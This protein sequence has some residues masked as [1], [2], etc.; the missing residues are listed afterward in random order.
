MK[1]SKQELHLLIDLAK[2]ETIP[3]TTMIDSNGKAY[4]HAF[5]S[6]YLVTKNK[7]LN[8]RTNNPLVLH[9]VITQDFG[10]KDISFTDIKNFIN[11]IK[12]RLNIDKYF[13]N[14]EK[15]HGLSEDQLNLVTEQ[16]ISKAQ[17]EFK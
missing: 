2:L 10:F 8:Y 5:R 4:K 13:S 12:S 16:R 6:L 15:K 17:K 1:P 9:R 14:V 7:H 3:G 11:P